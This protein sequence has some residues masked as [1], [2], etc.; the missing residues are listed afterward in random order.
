M[1][2]PLKKGTNLLRLTY[3]DRTASNSGSR[4]STEAYIYSLED[5]FGV[6]TVALCIIA[7]NWKLL[8]CPSAVEWIECDIYTQWRNNKAKKM[9]RLELNAT[10]LVTLS[11]C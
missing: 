3:V 2:N 8:K 4:H 5:T 11:R 7:S 9:S 10:R 1:I 6:F